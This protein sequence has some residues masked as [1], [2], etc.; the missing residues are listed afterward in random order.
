MD[1]R[2]FP[3]N[4]VPPKPIAPQHV[5]AYSTFQQQF[6]KMPEFPEPTTLQKIYS[7]LRGTMRVLMGKPA[8]PDHEPRKRR[9]PNYVNPD[10][11]TVE[12]L[13]YRFP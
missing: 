10:I 1:D 7:N 5:D 6:G 3:E 8:N 2:I 9:D 11:A 13:P 12:E 4:P